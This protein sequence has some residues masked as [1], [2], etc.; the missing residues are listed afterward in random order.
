[1]DRQKLRGE[2][3][4]L[5]AS[6][7][8]V[9][10]ILIDQ[11]FLD[12]N[13]GFQRVV[14]PKSGIRINGKLS[15]RGQEKARE[16]FDRLDERSTGGLGFEEYRTMKSLKHPYDFVHQQEWSSWE[17]WRMYM[18]DCGIPTNIHGQIFSDD[19]LRHRIDIE[20]DDPLM[21]DL[22][23][24]CLGYLQAPL[25]M[26]AK[27]KSLLEET[28]NFRSADV[29]YHGRL[30]MEES[31]Y[32]LCNAGFCYS[33]AE[34]FKLMIRRVKFENL[35]NNLSSKALKGNLFLSP[36]RLGRLFEGGKLAIPESHLDLEEIA[37]ISPTHLVGW[38]FSDKLAP[39]S[40]VSMLECSKIEILFSFVYYSQRA[41]YNKLMHHYCF[42]L[43]I[44][45][46]LPL[47]MQ[48]FD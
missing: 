26:W 48:S 24:A 6:L 31:S 38:I 22:E 32:V 29:E 40:P 9:E 3:E 18:A 14:V 37:T 23:A 34:L 11:G 44:K 17:A 27:I 33:K 1:M 28:T 45:E 25:L 2:I 7:H 21:T 36:E 13:E 47:N 19:L 8:A 41:N 42:S 5:Q 43:C 39:V 4:D 16:M 46:L 15:F 20:L 12:P 30:N 10:Y 35:M